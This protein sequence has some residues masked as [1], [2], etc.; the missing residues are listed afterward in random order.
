M[1]QPTVSK[2]EKR[3]PTNNELLSWFIFHKITV[4]VNATPDAIYSWITEFYD[5]AKD[6]HG[7]GKIFD[8]L[9]HDY[10]GFAIFNK[11]TEWETK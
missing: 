8:L 9:Y 10:D 3:F 5:I 7:C 2:M 4:S 1:M 6:Y 11:P